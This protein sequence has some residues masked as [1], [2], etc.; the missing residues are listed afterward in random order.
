L[1]LL[2]AHIIS[3]DGIVLFIMLTLYAHF[4]FYNAT[5]ELY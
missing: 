5:K 2:L 3:I 1:L 4:G